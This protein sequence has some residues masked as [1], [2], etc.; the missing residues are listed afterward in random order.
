MGRKSVALGS[1]I[2][3]LACLL[4]SG[5][6]L[7]AAPTN[8]D[9][10]AA[11]G[12][13]TLPFAADP[14]L[15][16]ATIEP[17]EPGDCQGT[18]TS[19]IWYSYT[20]STTGQVRVTLDGE[21]GA[22]IQIAVFRDDGPGV[23][24]LTQLSCSWSDVTD[25]LFE[26]VGGLHYYVQLATTRPDL[27]A[28]HLAITIPAPPGNDGFA[29]ATRISSLPFAAERE[30]LTAASLELGEPTDCRI[31]DRTVWFDYVAPA[32]GSLSGTY[33]AS[34]NAQL[35]V[36]TGGT[37]SGLTL[38]DCYEPTGETRFALAVRQ[39][40]TYHLRMSVAESP[41]F[42][43]GVSLDLREAPA[44]Y[45]D[46]RWSPGYPVA[47]EEIRFADDSSDTAGFAIDG[48]HWQFDDGTT[49]EGQVV[50]RHY[51]RNGDYP[52]TLTIHTTD[53]RKASLT[54]TVHVES[55]DIRISRFR[56]PR[57]GIV[58]RLARIEVRVTSRFGP[59]SGLVLIYRSTSNGEVELAAV[60]VRIPRS[61]HGRH[62]TVVVKDRIS[63]EDAVA[64]TVTYRVVVRYEMP[65][66]D[67][68]D[69]QAT[70]PPMRVRR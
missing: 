7:A 50:F 30:D 45:V 1:L 12:I 28:A 46:F 43:Y 48:W 68:S 59:E 8:D 70:A 11:T 63:A 62:A 37:L 10:A 20:P 42:Q 19:S 64:G 13:G 53:G 4:L 54:K 25:I 5:V 39:G 55:H 67:P 35:A 31:G 58:G 27:A 21:F 3:V 34:S 32:D 22:L 2:A 9:L 44:P 47:G 40:E 24:G 41:F 65:D 15:L 51:A 14:V 57:V 38:I 61:G 36:F 23:S 17:G 60:P 29:S 69:N 56:V 33:Q 26:A 49:A 6:A 66:V 18:P 16:D 52:V